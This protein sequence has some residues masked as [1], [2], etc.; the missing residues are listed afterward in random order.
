MTAPS[1]WDVMEAG[2][3]RVD[4]DPLSHVALTGPQTAFVQWDARMGAWIDANQLGKSFGLAVLVLRFLVT[5]SE[6]VA[7][8]LRGWA[9]GW[10]ARLMR[11]PGFILWPTPKP[12]VSSPDG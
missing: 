5:C 7:S 6:Q 9:D 2:Q 4:L 1:L 8:R 11:S 12:P 10:V 3:E